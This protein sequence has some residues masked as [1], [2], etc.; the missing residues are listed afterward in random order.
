[1]PNWA[2]SCWVAF[3]S[4]IVGFIL[5]IFWIIMAGLVLTMYL[6]F[7]VN[8]IAQY[9]EQN[10]I[11]EIYQAP[12]LLTVAAVVIFFLILSSLSFYAV[13][14][15]YTWNEIHNEI[16]KQLEKLRQK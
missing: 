6:R 14:V 7:E 5:S 16:E 9:V 1:M 15:K 3:W 8:T 11:Y 10:K 2:K 13:L 4:V 12:G